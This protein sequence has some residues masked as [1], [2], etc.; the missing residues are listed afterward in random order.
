V[1]TPADPPRVALTALGCKVNFAEMADLAGRLA[2]LGCEIV[3]DTDD[4][5][6][7]VLNSCTVTLQADATTR[8][9]LHRLRRR[10]PGAHLI[11]TGC[12][13][14]ANPG[15]YTESVDAVFSN[16]DKEGIAD[17]V[18]GLLAE[19]PL[20][21]L[22]AP[23]A[24]SRFFLKAQDGCDHRCTY[25]IV[26]SARG[27]SRSRSTDELVAAARAAV[28]AGHEEI[29]L[30]G[31][32]LGSYGRRQNTT[33]AALVTRLL[34]EVGEHARLRLSS[35]NANDISAD[36]IALNAHPSLC[37]HWHIP[38]Q[39]GSD[40][41]LKAMHRG[42][43]RR[44]Y[45]RVAEGLRQA[46]PDT[47][48]TTDVMVAFPGE[49]EADHQDTLALID[50]VAMLGC[51]TFRWS[52]RPGTPAT[53]LGDRVD[54]ATARRRSAEVRRAATGTADARRHRVT[55]RRLAVVWESVEPGEARGL[56]P[57][58]HEVVAAPGPDTRPGRI[59]TVLITEV[60]GEHL[61][62]TLCRP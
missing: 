8:Q 62:G 17:H 51:H 5:D 2:S 4:A 28:A 35:I 30:T 57:G 7:R 26:W 13:V 38:L 42:Y 9:R 39:S 61:R 24:R 10:D 1:T 27:P 19:R 60:D 29:V 14:D 47:E 48:I 34:A 45:L 52:P 36:L 12:S 55:G 59:E 11:V 53:E 41:I 18:A 44:Q 3:P 58:Y 23:R 6:I 37:G 21:A 50:E 16:R 40:R 25:C 49:S 20:R 43:R 15:A 54:D 32:D 56:S 22:P 46:D 33:L 31:V